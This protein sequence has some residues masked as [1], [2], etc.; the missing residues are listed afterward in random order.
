M[1]RAPKWAFPC[2]KVVR[3]AQGAVERARLVS[4][5]EALDRAGNKVSAQRPQLPAVLSQL[6]M[7]AFYLSFSI[8]AGQEGTFK[9][10]NNNG[11]GFEG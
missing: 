9:R 6:A 4:L 10:K 11:T 8:L 2:L 1:A 5:F 3:D 7:A